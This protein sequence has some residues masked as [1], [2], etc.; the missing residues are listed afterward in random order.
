[1]KP[2]Q[3]R[4]L[5]SGYVV[6]RKQLRTVVALEAELIRRRTK[7]A[8][9]VPAKGVSYRRLRP[10][11]RCFSDAVSFSGSSAMLRVSRRAP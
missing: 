8:R 2:L 11:F 3:I 5:R 7:E 6:G 9:V 10:R 4:I 1:V